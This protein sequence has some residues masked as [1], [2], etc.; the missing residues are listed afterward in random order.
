[1][2]APVMSPCIILLPFAFYLLPSSLFMSQCIFTFNF[3][4]LTFAL[5][6]LS[7]RFRGRFRG[8]SGALLLNKYSSTPVPTAPCAKFTAPLFYFPANHRFAPALAHVFIGFD[9]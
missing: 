1:M 7:G 3:C 5:F 4:L 2:E 9:R 6:T 8:V